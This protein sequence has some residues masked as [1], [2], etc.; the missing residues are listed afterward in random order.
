MTQT[1][2]ISGTQRSLALNEGVGRLTFTVTNTKPTA[3]RGRALLEIQ[4]ADEHAERLRTCIHVPIETPHTFE[5]R[6]SL[7]VT[8]DIKIPAGLEH[9]HPHISLNVGTEEAPEDDHTLSESV[10]LLDA[11]WAP[12]EPVPWWR[13]PWG[14]VVLTLG[15]VLLIGGAVWSYR[16]ATALRLTG[17]S[18]V[19][20]LELVEQRDLSLGDITWRLETETQRRLLP[21][22]GEV[23]EWDLSGDTVDLTIQYRHPYTE[24]NKLSVRKANRKAELNAVRAEALQYALDE[25]TPLRSWLE[26]VP[27]DERGDETKPYRAESWDK[28]HVRP[29]Q[30]MVD[31][32]RA[33]AAQAA[34]TATEPEA[35]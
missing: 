2:S 31:E 12:I 29:S 24:R 3:V 26:L 22:S 13:R 14:I 23:L 6:T 5:A 27:D 25:Y 11:S 21:L 35:P 19:E 28:I 20:A 15:A 18:L 32:A 4:G 17:M 33:E 10:E 8:L 9:C 30:A 1:F 16:A 34:L 7:A